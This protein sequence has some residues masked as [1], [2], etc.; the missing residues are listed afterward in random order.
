MRYSSKGFIR[1]GSAGYTLVEILVVLFVLAI[2]AVLA[3]ANL[4]P[5]KEKAWAANAV[6]VLNALRQGEIDYKE[7]HP[8]YL[9]VASGTG[10]VSANWRQLGME[11]PSENKFS[12]SFDPN[13]SN[14][15]AVAVRND[16][17]HMNKKITVTV[18]TSAT[19]GGDYPFRPKNY[20]EA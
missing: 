6:V 12:Y 13:P 19:W 3:F 4:S 10:A 9:G 7:D 11:V 5:R 16:G 17:T 2:V 15:L 14:P 18:D 8:A 1:S 20:G